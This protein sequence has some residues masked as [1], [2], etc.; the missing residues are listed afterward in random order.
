MTREVQTMKSYIKLFIAVIAAL[1]VLLAGSAVILNMTDSG[2]S[3]RP[4]RVEAERLA[5]KIENNESYSLDDYICI[6]NVE[7][8]S[9]S[10]ETGNSDYLIKKINGSYYR[11]D[12]TYQSDS[13]SSLSVF[14]FC[15]GAV[16]VFVIG[17]LIYI[18]FKII[19]PFE[20]LADYPAE[21]AKG[22]LT[23]PLKDQKNGY[24][25]KFLW[26]LDLLREKLEKQRADELELK[27]Q[28]NT[29]VLALSH[30]IKTPV[31][32]IELYAKALEKGLY[33]DEDKKKEISL[34]IYAKCEEIRRYIDDIAKTETEDF[35]SLEVNIGEFYLS[36]L[37]TAIKSFYSEKLSLLKTDFTVGGVTD[38]IISGDKERCVEVVQNIIENAVKYGDGKRIAISFSKEEDCQLIHISN[39]GC[40]LPDSELPHVFDCF[41]RGSN[42]GT[43]SGSGLGLYICRKLTNKMNGDI[44]AGISDGEM[45]VT[46]VLPLA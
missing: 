4:Y 39:S 37:M 33:K 26:G 43:R 25:G 22:D 42:A 46:V 2:T 8:L 38:C 10:I 18:Y 17:S 44:Y 45:T 36:E 29:M 12:Y 3:G 23:K 11:F 14:Y 24:F 27:K 13:K 41:W 40:T 7:K 9:D 31:G 1:A 19:R 15:F 28:N 30:D 21:L 16:C 35:L 34:N 5:K 6:T 20:K 32:V